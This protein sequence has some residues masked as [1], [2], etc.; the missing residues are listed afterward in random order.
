M[1]FY[2]HLIITLGNNQCLYISFLIDLCRNVFL[3]FPIDGKI[4]ELSCSIITYNL[5]FWNKCPVPNI[6]Q[7]NLTLSNKQN[8]FINKLKII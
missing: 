6:T 2:I 7:P 1:T 4:Y 3:Y 8:K 5:K